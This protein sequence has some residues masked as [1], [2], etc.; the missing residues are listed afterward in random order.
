MRRWRCCK[1]VTV[2]GIGRSAADHGPV[3]SADVRALSLA[4]AAGRLAIGLGLAI[5]PRRAL[6]LLGL[7]ETGPA[8]VMVARLA[9]V[10]DIVLGVVTL[11]SLQDTAALRRASL[12]NAAAD[13]GDSLT[14]VVALASRDVLATPALRGLAGAVPATL[15]GL[16]VA[17]RLR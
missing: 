15:G 1:A 5:A 13:A 8:T 2:T 3:R 6:A 11:A 17:S 16:W 12:A 10:R 9:A 4:S 7:E 14:F